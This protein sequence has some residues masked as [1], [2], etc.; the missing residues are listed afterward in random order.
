MKINKKKACKIKHKNDE[1]NN[2]SSELKK[3]NSQN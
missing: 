2:K 1:N 3:E